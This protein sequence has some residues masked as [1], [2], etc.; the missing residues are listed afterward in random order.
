VRSSDAL[1][2][3]SFSRCGSCQS[4]DRV[5]VEAALPRVPQPLVEHRVERA[6]D[7]LLPSRLAGLAEDRHRQRQRGG[8]GE[9]GLDAESAVLLVVGGEDGLDQYGE[10][11][12]WGSAFAGAFGASFGGTRGA[13]RRSARH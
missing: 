3:S 2:S 5:A 7:D 12:V 10:V 4:R 8:V 9:L 6:L 11:E 13:A 1:V